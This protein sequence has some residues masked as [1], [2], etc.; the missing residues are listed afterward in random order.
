M[1][2][3]NRVPGVAPHRLELDAAY[4]MP[5]NWYVVSRAV[6]ASEMAVNDANSS[7]SPAYAIVNLRGGFHHSRVGL[8]T[9]SLYVGVSNLF[10]AA[11][12]SSVTVNAFGGRYCEPGPARSIWFGATLA[13]TTR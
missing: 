12:N 2:A 8:L 1:Y 10:A 13:I 6:F 3:G 11:C 9:L 7:H 4:D 5:G